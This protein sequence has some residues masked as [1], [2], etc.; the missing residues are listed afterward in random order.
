MEEGKSKSKLFWSRTPFF[1]DQREREKGSAN[2]MGIRAIKYKREY[3][4]RETFIS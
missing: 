2:E 4:E 1:Q 3:F